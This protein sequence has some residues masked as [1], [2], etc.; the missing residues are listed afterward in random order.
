MK[1]NDN[2]FYGLAINLMSGA[3][4]YM[5]VACIHIDVY[6]MDHMCGHVL[7]TEYNVDVCEHSPLYYV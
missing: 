2:T 3:K 7:H 6:S 1:I 5:Y 4:S